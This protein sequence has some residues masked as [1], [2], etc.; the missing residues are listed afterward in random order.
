V[1]TNLEA[2]PDSDRVITEGGVL[3]APGLPDP[4]DVKNSDDPDDYGEFGD[5]YALPRLSTPLT[6]TVATMVLPFSLLLSLAQILYG[7]D[8]PGDGFTAGVV[9]GLAVGLWYVV[10]GYFEARVRL[11]WLYPGR[12]VIAG[13]AL[14]FGN[15]VLNLLVNGAFLRIIDIGDGPA[16][17]HLASTLLFELGIYLTVFGG[18]TLIMQA[19]AHPSETDGL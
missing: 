8:G 12:L 4:D 19:I 18:V 9:S 2:M 10:F 5:A 17:I 11:R 16:E 1:N 15:A 14:A 7:G 6:R 3:S 13:L